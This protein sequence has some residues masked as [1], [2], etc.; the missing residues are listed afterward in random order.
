M[1]G[2]NPGRNSGRKP[3]EKKS[4]L[5]AGDKSALTEELYSK[6]ARGGIGVAGIRVSLYFFFKKYSW[7]CVT[8]ST[9][10]LKRTIDIISSSI[11]LVLISPLFLAT[12]VAIKVEDPGPAFYS[13]IRVGKWG[14][15]SPCTNSGP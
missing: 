12:V 6:Y 2:D 7:I 4:Q 13:Q 3:D 14:N 11:L 5:E 1:A 8:E 9:Y 15:S 10:F